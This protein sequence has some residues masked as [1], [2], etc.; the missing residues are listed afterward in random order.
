MW[1]R[2]NLLSPP[3]GTETTCYPSMWYR[4]NMLSP[5]VVP[6]QLAIPDQ[7]CP[8]LSTVITIIQTRSVEFPGLLPPTMDP[9]P[10]TSKTTPQ[11][12]RILTPLTLSPIHPQIPAATSYTYLGAIILLRPRDL[13]LIAAKSLAKMTTCLHNLYAA[14]QR[15][16]RAVC[17]E[18]AQKYVK[19]SATEAMRRLNCPSPGLAHF[20]RSGSS[21]ALVR[22]QP[23]LPRIDM[24][25]D[26]TYNI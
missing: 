5:H 17:D 20:T 8:F 2:N 9:N 12:P 15:N 16:Y 3:C 25:Y 18:E 4:N 19:G 13:V 6:K 22:N 7:S 1:Y 23:H 14:K 10:R 26:S 24:K 21:E 11:R